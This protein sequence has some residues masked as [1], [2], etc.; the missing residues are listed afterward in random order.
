MWRLSIAFLALLQA[1]PVT[2]NEDLRLTLSAV[3]P[4]ILVGE[5]TK[6]KAEWTALRQVSVLFGSE[7]VLIDAG[8]GFEP[9]AEA[10]RSEATFLSTDTTLAIG[11]RRLTEHTLGLRPVPADPNLSGLEELHASVGFVFDRPGIYRVKLRHE[12]TESNAVEIEVVAPSGADA[13]LLETLRPRL[14]LLTPT[15]G[16]DETLIAEGDA[17]VQAHGAHPYLVPFVQTRFDG[18]SRLNFDAR[19]ALDLGPSALAADE[20]LWRAETGERFFDA[21]WLQAALQQ[22]VATF[23]GRLAAERA[24]EKLRAFD[25]QPPVLAV[26]ATPSG[27]WPPNGKM[28]PINVVVQLADNVDGVPVLRL[29]SITCDDGCVPAT[30]ID[31]AAFGTDD[32]TFRLRARRSGGGPGRTYTITYAATDSSQNQSTATATVRVAHDQ[33]H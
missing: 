24:A 33:G 27:L 15:G 2:T 21:T 9:H 32:R 14:G 16:A 17:L 25:S 30:D 11:E 22:I 4:R 13:A 20:L 31:S 6:V 3:K 26:S 8:S 23:P 10:S 19:S 5:F 18:P 29:V 1:P 12:E 7:I 28:V